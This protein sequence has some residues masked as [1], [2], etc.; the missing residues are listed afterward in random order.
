MGGAVGG[1]AAPA[2]RP[3]VVLGDLRPDAA[4]GLWRGAAGDVVRH[5]AG[6]LMIG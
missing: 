3:V 6:L 5:L 4:G 1:L 2:A